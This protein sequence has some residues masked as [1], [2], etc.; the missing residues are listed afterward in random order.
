MTGEF[1]TT[2]VIFSLFLLLG[3]TKEEEPSPVVPPA[4][5][6]TRTDSS[7]PTGGQAKSDVVPQVE[8]DSEAQKALMGRMRH[9]KRS[10]EP[11]VG[12]CR[13]A[14]G[15]A[16]GAFKN[17]ARSVFLENPPADLPQPIRFIDTTT[18]V[19]NGAELGRQWARM[20]LDGQLSERKE[21][22]DNWLKSYLLRTGGKADPQLLEASL[23]SGLQFRRLSSSQ[24]EFSWSRP[25]VAGGSTG[26]VWVV[27]MNLRA[28]QW[29]VSDI[30][31][32][33]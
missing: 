9:G 11:L 1:R 21:S 18:L 28:L 7:T 20:Y 6:T 5:S 14:C 26:D 4:G 2:V 15:D 16:K 22:V 17:F 30:R 31:D 29:L 3:C 10:S 8:A 19:D 23:E 27:K 25:P 32:N 13:D 33:P 24:V 12:G